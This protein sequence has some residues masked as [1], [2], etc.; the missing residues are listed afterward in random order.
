MTPGGPHVLVVEDDANVIDAYRIVFES[1]G[2]RFSSAASVDDAVRICFEEHPD[3]MFLDLRLRH[4]DGLDVLLALARHG[5]AAPAVFALTG[6]ADPD[7]LA[8]CRAAGVRD[9]LLKPV[10]WRDLVRHA[11]DAVA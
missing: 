8:R 11:R 4:E 10:P 6:D 9:V 5:A 2:H 1:A 3:V 7:L